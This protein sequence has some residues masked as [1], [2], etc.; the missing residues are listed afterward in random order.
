MN[1]NLENRISMYY[2][3]REFFSNH[4]ATLMAKGPTVAI[5]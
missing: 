5:A 1:S 4:L 3:V 2:K